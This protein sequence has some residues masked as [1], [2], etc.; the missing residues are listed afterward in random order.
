MNNNKRITV[1]IMVGGK[2]SR[3]GQN[4]AWLSYG[5][6][7]FVNHLVN[8]L[9]ALGPV[10]L[11]AAQEQ[12][13]SYDDLGCKVLYDQVNNCG[14]LAGIQSI[15]EMSDTELSF[16]CAVDMAKLSAELVGYLQE[17]CATD[18]DC[19]CLTVQGKLEPL[20]ALYRKAAL[21]K[22]REQLKNQDY[23][24]LHL[25]DKLRTK[26]VCLEWSCFTSDCT[27][28]INT[29]QEY[30]AL[31]HQPKLFCIS[32]VKNSGKTTLICDLLPLFKADG[33]RVSVIK[34]DGHEFTVDYP[35]TD[36]A[37][38]IA[39]GA[40]QSLIYDSKHYAIMGNEQVALEELLNFCS[41]SDFIIVEGAKHS[42]L[43]KV[44]VVRQAISGEIVCCQEGL[45]AIYTDCPDIG[46]AKVPRFSF[47]QLQELYDYIIK[48]I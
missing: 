37:K 25:L 18:Y 28:N 1:G 23:K 44:E 17:F 24:L 41:N 29:P 31:V 20:C 32:G 12:K 2:S 34:H 8:E 35:G 19:V 43:P 27:T 7:S 16:I 33:Y 30:K 47:N 5:E 10:Y 11:A 21:N 39:A 40:E 6:S 9:K 42:S 46:E 45:L 13:H 36:T 3:M 14:P 26:Y 22:V 48:I 38:F 15:L 4:K